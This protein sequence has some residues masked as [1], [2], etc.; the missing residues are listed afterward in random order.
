MN[1]GSSVQNRD[2]KRV[3]GLEKPPTEDMSCDILKSM[4]VD[5]YKPEP[6]LQEADIL[7]RQKESG[8]GYHFG[9]VVRAEV[10]APWMSAYAYTQHPDFLVA[11]TMPGIGKHPGTIEK[12]FNGLPGM[13]LRPVRNPYQRSFVEQVAVS[14]LGRGYGLFES[15]ETDITRVHT[16]VPQ[17]PT[18]DRVVAIGTVLLILGL[19]TRP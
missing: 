12:F 9:T 5:W 19:L 17:N 7:I 4:I 13:V 6:P 3:T 18:A 14:D 15:C 11:H 2:K 10:A 1:R 16:G 8:W